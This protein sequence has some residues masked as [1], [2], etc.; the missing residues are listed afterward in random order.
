MESSGVSGGVKALSEQMW[1]EPLEMIKS[2]VEGN[3]FWD[4]DAQ[5]IRYIQQLRGKHRTSKKLQQ[6]MNQTI[7]DNVRFIYSRK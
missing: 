7:T 6:N 3:F 2:S 4:S 1:Q 5:N